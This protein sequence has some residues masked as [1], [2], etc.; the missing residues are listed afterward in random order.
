[1]AVDPHIDSRVNRR[2]PGWKRISLR[3]APLLLSTCG[4]PGDIDGAP[5]GGDPA[6]TA[7]GGGPTPGGGDGGVL[8]V[9]CPASSV[10]WASSQN[11]V[12]VT[13]PVLCTLSELARHLSPEVLE[14]T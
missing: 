2:R 13:G 4:S 12:Y 1:M 7:D 3:V 9:G 6:P 8:A 11:R 14:R 10:R 5:G